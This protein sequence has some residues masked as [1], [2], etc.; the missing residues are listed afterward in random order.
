MQ[1]DEDDLPRYFERNPTP[2]PGEANPAAWSAGRFTELP[3]DDTG[4]EVESEMDVD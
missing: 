2:M 1:L 4:M 3:D